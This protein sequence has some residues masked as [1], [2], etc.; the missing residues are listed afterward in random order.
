MGLRGPRYQAW[1]ALM[2]RA[3]GL[4]VL[5]YP[6]CGGRLRLI[7]TISDLAV[8]AQILA[9]LGLT[10]LHRPPGLAPPAAAVIAQP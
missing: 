7:V 2:H 6:R 9:H 1:A 10:P 5:A 3:F 4:D 8:V